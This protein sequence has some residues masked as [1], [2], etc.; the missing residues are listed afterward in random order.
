MSSESFSLKERINFCHLKQTLSEGVKQSK[1][2][3]KKNI[4]KSFFLSLYNPF[5]SIQGFKVS[6]FGKQVKLQMKT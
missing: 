4:P 6:V 1:T 2:K 3:W 5:H